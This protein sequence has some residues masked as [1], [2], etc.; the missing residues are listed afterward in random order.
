MFKFAEI[1]INCN[2]LNAGILLEYCQ[3][4]NIPLQEDVEKL[5]EADQIKVLK[6][7]IDL[8]A[9]RM[10]VIFDDET[11]EK[12]PGGRHQ[13]NQLF[14]YINTRLNFIKFQQEKN[15][16]DNEKIIYILLELNS[17]L[18]NYYDLMVELENTKL[19]K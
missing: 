12:I 13:H 8:E 4:E 15:Q 6:K 18:S 14:N 2:E 1:E 17:A 7:I 16:I 19:T 9:D 5:V 10:T 3:K 11:L